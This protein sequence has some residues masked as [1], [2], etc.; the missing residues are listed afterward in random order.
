MLQS[1]PLM[2][3]AATAMELPPPPA[4]SAHVAVCCGVG[5]VDAAAQTARVLA[6][7][8]PR[9]VLHVGIAGARRASGLRPGQ[10]VI[11]QRA[12]YH[13]LLI[14]ARFAPRVVEA[15]AALLQAAHAALPSAVLRDIGTSARVGG[16]MT[17]GV[18]SG[19]AASGEATSH[20]VAGVEVEAME[21]FAVLRACQLAGVPA[22]EIRVISNAIE[23]HDRTKWQFA[24]AF[25]VLHAL[26]PPLLAAFDRTVGRTLDRTLDREPRA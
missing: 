14:D 6:V 25:G 13:D 24:E 11:G 16:T 7:H 5:P 15:D 9:A 10:V 18:P 8:A 1:A 3:I 19:E 20:A 21:G 17:G 26:V 23:E 12:L 4:T 2:I 22:L